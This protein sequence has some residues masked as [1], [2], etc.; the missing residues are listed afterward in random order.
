M[1][2]GILS[3]VFFASLFLFAPLAFAQPDL[4][5]GDE[6]DQVTVYDENAFVGDLVKGDLLRPD[7]SLLTGRRPGKT[8]SLIKVR[9]NFKPEIIKSVE[10]L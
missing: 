10:N 2:R 7:G 1:K 4:S 8:S 5:V 3:A 9:T 6:T